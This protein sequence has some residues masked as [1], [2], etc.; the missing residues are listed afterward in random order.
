M[1][2]YNYIDFVTDGSLKFNVDGPSIRDPSALYQKQTNK[3]KI[4]KKICHHI[5]PY[6]DIY[7]F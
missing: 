6:E 7:S 5:S 4:K 1:G 2:K 3:K